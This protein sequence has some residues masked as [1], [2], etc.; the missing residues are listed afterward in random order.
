MT[1]AALFDETAPA[2]PPIHV[3]ASVHL[4]EAPRL[5]KQCAA[6]LERFRA[7]GGVA[8]NRELSEIALKYTSRLSDLRAAGYKV[9]VLQRDHESGLNTYRLVE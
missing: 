2:Q 6:I 7:N 5:S 1:Q 4:A 3:N 9:V 8:T